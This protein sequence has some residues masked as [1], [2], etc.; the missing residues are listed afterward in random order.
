[1]NVTYNTVSTMTAQT[2]V[3]VARSGFSPLLECS[4]QVKDSAAKPFCD[5]CFTERG[6]VSEAMGT[7][8]F[9]CF[10]FLFFVFAAY[11]QS[12]REQKI[13]YVGQVEKREN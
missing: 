8:C 3:S 10:L 7:L 13:M 11:E 2:C 5:Y 12:E 9:F 4:L 6:E 1:M